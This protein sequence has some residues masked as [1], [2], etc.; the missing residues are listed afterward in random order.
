MPF[1]ML[2]IAVFIA[3]FGAN[4]Y[5]AA[6]SPLALPGALQ[7]SEGIGIIAHRG[8]AA[9]APENTLAAA[10][11]GIAQGVEFLEVDAQL[12][13]DGVPVL[14]H[15]PTVERTTNGWGPIAQLTLAEV[16]TLDAGGWFSAE[17]AGEPVPTLEEFAAEI[18][19]TPARA[20]VELKGEWRLEQVQAALDLLRA[21]GMVNRVALQ[22]F[23]LGMLEVLREEAPE[24]ALVML[25][26][27]WTPTIVERAAQLQVSAIGARTKLLYARPALMDRAQGFGI[28]TLAYTLNS[29]KRW[30]AANDR[31]VDFVVT[32]DPVG[33]ADWRGRA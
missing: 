16:K 15:D 29:E 13:A 10:R 9:V 5:A 24:F 14:M 32:D 12:T 11:A 19:G 8:A 23:D 1:Q 33:L 30:A 27:E 26:R 7:S 3:V 6:V 2:V 4:P 17:F 20:L 25:T 21:R 22:S 18:D 31:G 28:G